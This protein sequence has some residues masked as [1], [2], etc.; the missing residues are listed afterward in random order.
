MR[1]KIIDV[2][3]KSVNVQKAR[4]K[5]GLDTNANIYATF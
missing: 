1:T 3:T 2:R 4:Q 5:V